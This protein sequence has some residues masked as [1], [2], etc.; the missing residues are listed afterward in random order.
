[1]ATPFSRSLAERY[2]TPA[3]F[4]LWT[5]W[6]DANK[7]DYISLIG[8]NIEQISFNGT[9]DAN[10]GGPSNVIPRFLNRSYVNTWG[11][12]G[13]ASNEIFLGEVSLTEPGFS[14]RFVVA[15]DAGTDSLFIPLIQA[16]H[17]KLE[18]NALGL[19][20]ISFTDANAR[21]SQ[22]ILTGVESI[23]YI[24]A[25]YSPTNPSSYNLVNG[26]VRSDSV[27][28]A[29][30]NSYGGTSST[31]TTSGTIGNDLILAAT[32]G[33]YNTSLYTS[34]DGLAGTDVLLFDN[35]TRANLTDIFRLPSTQWRLTFGGIVIIAS[36]I[37][38]LQLQDMAV[39]LNAD[40]TYTNI[41]WQPDL[42]PS[43]YSITPSVSTISEGSVLTT[44]VQTANVAENTALYWSLGGTGITAADFSSGAL[45]GTG[46]VGVDGKFSFSHT[47]ANDQAREGDESLQI[48][49]F[50]DPGRITQVGLTATV[51]IKDTSNS[52]PASYAV[53]PSASQVDEGSVLVT[54]IS[55]SNI[56]PYTKLYWSLSGAGI[57]AA[58]LLSGALTGAG[59]VDA[60]GKFSFSHVI[61]NDQTTE[62]PESIDIKL[63]S[64]SQRSIQVGD[65]AKVVINDT[66]KAS[67]SASFGY[68]LIS[69][70]FN[71][72]GL[73]NGLLPNGLKVS[74]LGFV[75][76][77][78]DF[79]A[80]KGLYV[81]ASQLFAQSDGTYSTAPPFSTEGIGGG[82]W[83]SD[84]WGYEAIDNFVD[85]GFGASLTKSIS[86]TSLDR[87]YQGIFPYQSEKPTAL[88]IQIYNAK[89]NSDF[90][91]SPPFEIRNTAASEVQKRSASLLGTIIVSAGTNVGDSAFLL[92][93]LISNGVSI[94]N[95]YSNGSMASDFLWNSLR[96]PATNSEL[97][98]LVDGAADTTP[99]TVTLAVSPAQVTED[100]TS[101][102]GYTFFRTGAITSAL[103]VNYSIAGTA[104][105]SD[106]TGATPGTS[107]TITF[108]AGSA[109]T[110]L[111]IDPK[112]DTIIE[113]D[114]TVGLMLATGADYTVGTATPVIGTI[115]NDDQNVFVLIKAVGTV[116]LG[117]TQLGYALQVGSA[118]PI[119]IT[120]SGIGASATSPGG[121]WS[122][123]GAAANGTGF[124]LYLKNIDGS[125]AIWNLNGT[126]AQT[127]GKLLSTAE[128]FAAESSLSNDLNADGSVGN[129]FSAIK[130]IGSVALGST[131]KG[132]ALQVGSG[133]PIQ[134]TYAGINAS[135]TSPGVGWSAIAAA[136]NGTGFDVY[137]KNVDGSYAIWN[138]NGT[139]AQTGGKLL[140]AAELLNG[141]VAI[142]S[143][144]SGEGQIGPFEL[145]GGTAGADSLTGLS[146]Q[147]IFGFGGAD[148]LTGGSSAASG[149]D[150]LIGGAGND[151]Y[152]LPSG[153]STLI[154]DFGGDAADSFA[155]TGLSLNGAST[156]FGTLEGGRH[157]VITD[158]TTNTR[159]SL[160][161][162]QNNSN[163]IESFQ[164]T[165]GAFSFA[166]LQ[167]KVTSLGASVVDS[168]LASWDTTQ[169]ASQLTNLGFGTGASVDSLINYY[170]T[171]D[172]AGAI[173]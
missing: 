83:G 127:G 113:R 86:L 171:V 110:A 54:N 24:N 150:I 136:A 140:G 3:G 100:G 5:V 101:N 13:G 15:G 58:D 118:N 70:N 142:R 78:L 135:P 53:S 43:T 169:G 46:A 151:S 153:K 18:R 115:T 56:A 66:S 14:S 27:Y 173:A 116:S 25:R 160:Y 107:K 80:Y 38:Y 123:I 111:T 77:Q 88:A 168:S 8:L 32:T 87:A 42:G 37:E 6:K 143:D 91:Y 9:Y 96:Q 68:S 7:T 84:R 45:T 93:R 30:S 102:L 17:L 109:T 47:I 129:P 31:S 73:L 74:G 2:T 126:G 79:G 35:W 147:V 161:D 49:L 156:K 95:S 139:G 26:T 137:L 121:G 117:T 21:I 29:S 64:D 10:N 90:S 75:N 76:S 152:V 158:S 99:P 51:L 36:N 124:D 16:N 138:L 170:K 131:A 71:S 165:D 28:L 34:F 164:L 62:G 55:T 146:K 72:G 59:S 81:T 94:P 125:Y 120:Y 122:A 162:W 40:G 155:S 23:D 149:F 172:L 154:A 148:T 157:L 65:A 132:Y 166:Q 48:S 119:Q 89:Q 12:K 134:I 163:K 103:T 167:Q 114:E 98:V 104:D 33:D 44:N 106:Y 144:L 69:A 130:S 50:V 92:S 60:D 52:L 11:F 61:A 20:R 63:F 108:A 22:Y 39:S 112:A 145:Q 128:F 85:T 1:M 133:S 97:L 57:T 19:S 82:G 67:L 105:S 41:A 159:L 141:E 4:D